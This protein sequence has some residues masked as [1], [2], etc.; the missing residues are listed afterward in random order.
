MWFGFG[1]ITLL[2]AFAVSVY[3]RTC[4]SWKG[5]TRTAANGRTYEHQEV[6]QK[7]KVRRVRLGVSAPTEFNFVARKE[8][9]HDRLFK[10]IGISVEMQVDAPE[11]DTTLYLESDARAIGTLLRDR[12]ALRRA[13]LNA[14]S[15]AAD[16]KLRR[17]RLQ[18]AYG[19]VWLEFR[20][21]D[22]KMLPATAQ[23]L[24]PDLCEF[25][26][27][28]HLCQSQADDVH[29][30]FVWR[31]ALLL[32]ISTATLVYG[33]IGLAHANMGRTDIIEQARLFWRVVPLGMVLSILFLL[34]ILGWLGRSSRTHLVLLEAALVGSAGFVL[35][36][37]GLAREA[38]VDFDQRPAQVHVMNDIHTEQRTTIGRNGRQRHYF[39]VYTA[40]WRP[41][42]SDPLR[43]EIDRS[44]FERLGET[45]M[46]TIRT[47]PGAL[48]FEW[49]ESIEPALR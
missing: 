37:F 38:N 41:G 12:P 6:R 28:L 45:R 7:G 23:A 13:I 32:S 4:A 44:S 27:G 36:T 39:Y 40:D 21:A 42:R 16:N 48:G 43:L 29:D 46:V 30:P 22:A 15:Y 19:R 14:F 33:V 5:E 10:W 2:T 3:A 20:T 31:A 11:F 25:A 8:R 24:V 18:C 35:S 9:L 49:V 26:D 17:M 47:R 34:L 1:L